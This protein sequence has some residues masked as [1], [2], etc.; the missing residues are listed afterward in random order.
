MTAE[1]QSCKKG[2]SVKEFCN[3]L[4]FPNLSSYYF[5]GCPKK[6]KSACCKE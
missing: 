2:V 3:G 4:S 5:D 6:P 1:C